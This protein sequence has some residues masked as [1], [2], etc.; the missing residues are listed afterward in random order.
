MNPR[1]K[2]VETVS[3]RKPLYVD[4]NIEIIWDYL[5]PTFNNKVMQQTLPKEVFQ[6]HYEC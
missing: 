1:F 4:F 3:S 5:K 2:A 6:N